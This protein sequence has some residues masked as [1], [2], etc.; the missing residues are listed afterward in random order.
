MSEQAEK[1][2]KHCFGNKLM[3]FD[4]FGRKVYKCNYNSSGPHGWTIDHIWPINGYDLTPGSNFLN[5][6][7]VLHFDSNQ[8]KADSLQGKIGNTTFAIVKWTQDE[9][10]KIIGR[11]QIKIKNEWVWYY[12]QW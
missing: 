12:D 9:Y 10:G 5:N 11:M 1:V 2:W 3:G 7:Q 8:E 6:K 4:P